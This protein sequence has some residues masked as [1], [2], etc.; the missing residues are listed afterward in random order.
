MIWD[1]GAWTRSTRTPQ[2]AYAKG[3]LK[4]VLDGEKL[5]GR[6]AL[7]RMG[8]KR[9][10]RR[11][12]NWLLIKERDEAAVPQS[13]DRGR[14]RQPEERRHRARA[15]MRSPPTATGSGDPAAKNPAPPPSPSRKPAS[16]I[17][18]A[19]KKGG[20]RP[21]RPQ[22]AT[23]ADRAPDGTRVVSRDQVRWLPPDGADRRRQ[24]AA[25]DPQRPRL[26]R[27][28]SGAGARISP[29]CRSTRR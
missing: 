16:R 14:R 7:V 29:N 21:I 8:G 27:E 13:G 17:S 5:H 1:R 20:C 4:F 24:G 26:D 19:P 9:A 12:E 18:P 11:G 6:W 22:L 3:K 28:V 15:S 23:A 25:V 10:G 2:A